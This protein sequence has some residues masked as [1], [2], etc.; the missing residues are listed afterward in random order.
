VGNLNAVS[1]IESIAEFSVKVYSWLLVIWWKW[2]W[3]W[4]SCF[5]WTGL[6][7]IVIVCQFW[8]FH[9]N[10]QKKML[11]LRKSYANCQYELLCAGT[12]NRNEDCATL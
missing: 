9:L 6:N 11:L 3:Y 8:F 7:W 4:H 5:I 10:F 2:L 12:R 1:D